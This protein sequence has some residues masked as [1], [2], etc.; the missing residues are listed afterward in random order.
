MKHL[1]DWT[2]HGGG[3]RRDEVV[4]VILGR[5]TVELDVTL[6]FGWHEVHHR[7]DTTWPPTALG[8]IDTFLPISHLFDL[9]LNVARHRVIRCDL[10]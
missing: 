6:A 4:A 2:N 5:S 3:Y 7:F 10:N 9:Q 8:D 1:A